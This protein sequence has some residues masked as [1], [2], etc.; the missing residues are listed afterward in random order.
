MAISNER[1]VGIDG[2]GVRLR[3]RADDHGG[4]RTVLIDGQDFIAR[5][6]R[7][8]LPRPKRIR[9][10]GLL[11]PAVKA[12]VGRRPRWRRPCARG[13]RKLARMPPAFLKRVAGID[14]ACC[15][16]CKLG[17][18]RTTAILPPER[19]GEHGA[20]A[21]AGGRRDPRRTLP[22]TLPA[23]LGTATDCL[24]PVVFFAALWATTNIESPRQPPAHPYQL[25]PACRHCR[26]QPATPL[27]ELAC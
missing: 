14:I 22:L 11:S 21:A 18:W 15:P 26:P 4:K 17:Q 13:Q 5:F 19:A 1:I 7:H 9:H 8:V 20:I 2:Q 10:Y 24:A 27:P 23:L 25:I 3:V 12:R 16:H 6:L